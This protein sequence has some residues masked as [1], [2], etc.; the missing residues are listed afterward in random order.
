MMC[1][2]ET[3]NGEGAKHRDQ[4]ASREMTVDELLMRRI[5]KATRQVKALNDLRDSLPQSFLSSGCSR[6]LAFIEPQL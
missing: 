1:N 2:R 5:E 4:I 3:D 6:I